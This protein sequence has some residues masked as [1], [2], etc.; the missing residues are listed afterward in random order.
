MQ[1]STL[2]YYLQNHRPPD[3][4]R[5]WEERLIPF[6]HI[7]LECSGRARWNLANNKGR[8]IEIGRRMWQS[9]GEEVLVE[10]VGLNKLARGESVEM[11]NKRAKGRFGGN[12]CSRKNVKI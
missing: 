2:S 6:E 12:F 10:V 4:Q 8:G 9:P 11:K 7:T 3:E 1:E 5:V